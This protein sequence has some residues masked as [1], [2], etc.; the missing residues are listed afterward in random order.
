MR[1]VQGGNFPI[2]I[3]EIK[4]GVEASIFGLTAE[5]SR[6]HELIVIDYPRYSIKEDY[7]ETILTEK[8]FRFKSP[9]SGNTSGLLRIW[10][11]F[12][13]INK[14]KSDICHLH[15]TGWMSFL[16][17]VLLKCRGQQLIVTIHGLAHIE[18]KNG[19][20]RRKTIKNFIKVIS[21]S[22]AE[23]MLINLS[24]TV[25]VD[26]EYVRD[27]LHLYL[28]QHKVLR[29]PDIFVIPQ[30]VNESYFKIN[31]NIGFKNLLAVGSIN[32]RKGYIKLL[33]SIQIL[34]KYTT[35][36]RLDIVGVISDYK[37]LEE[38]NSCIKRLKLEQNV[39]I[40]TD[41]S[42]EKLLELYT[43]ASLFVLHTQEES[44]GIVFCE[45][46]A[47]GLP[48]V[49]TNVGGVPYIVKEGYGGLLCDYGDIESFT[50]N[51]LK[52]LNNNDLSRSFSD[53]NRIE[54]QKY[55]WKNI[56]ENIISVYRCNLV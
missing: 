15:S 55:D 49:A 4:G 17:F 3:G 42:F 48:V 13:I 45:A 20:I 12:S 34:T 31:S 21:H 36:F 47:C 40:H 18:K 30:G 2:N 5:L 8:I 22:F 56:A 32:P 54:A 41:L 29:L 53:F 25:I 10:K 35:D 51:I 24:K 46:M 23:F 16:L 11:I 7:V 37:Y 1:I 14:S 39:L 9:F 44:Q 28:K 33:E 38:L 52:L 26:T 6:F 43:N 19:W 50:L 27:A